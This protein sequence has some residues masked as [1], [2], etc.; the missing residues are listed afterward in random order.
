MY[1][2]PK[3]HMPKVPLRPILS[4]T[5]SAH[6]EMSKWLASLLQPV[7]HRYTV[8]CISHSFTFADYIGK[9]DGQIDSFM[10]LFDV[11][12]LF[13]N[14]PLNGTITICADTLYNNPDSQPCIPKEVFVELLHSV[15]STVEFSFGNTIYRQI[16]GLAMGS[17][18]G[19]AL[20]NI[21]VGYYEEKLFSEI[22]KP[23]VYFRY[24]DD[25]FVIFQNEK[26]SEEFLN[27]LNGPHSSL[28]FTF[29]KV[30]NNSLPFLDVHVENT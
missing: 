17:P 18:L 27:K 4:M 12:S 11:S 30:K 1:G 10:C 16:D 9:L 5:G 13:T 7:L 8:H 25:T 21:F 24:V 2:V 6:H 23:A 28:Q 20:V 26:E 22:S 15:T 19:P 14:V 29:E 3:T